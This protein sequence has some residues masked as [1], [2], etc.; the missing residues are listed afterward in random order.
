MTKKQFEKLQDGQLL[1]IKRLSGKTV[2][3][4]ER[5][6]FRL[7]EH[8]G[9]KQNELGIVHGGE[10]IYLTQLDIATF[11]DVI[12]AIRRDEERH[13]NYKHKL[14]EAY[15]MNEKLEEKLD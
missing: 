11:D 8:F 5:K 13:N 2:V 9:K 10:V 12:A 3:V 4:F 7:S 15:A 14:Y 1:T 6:W